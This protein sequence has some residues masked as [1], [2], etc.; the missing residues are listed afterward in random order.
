MFGCLVRVWVD[1]GNDEMVCVVAWMWRE[2]SRLVLAV[3]CV[4]RRLYGLQYRPKWGESEHKDFED[5]KGR[6]LG[7]P[8][9]GLLNFVEMFVVEADA[10]DVGIGT[11]C[12][13]KRTLSLRMH[14]QYF[15]RLWRELSKLVSAVEC[16]GR[17]LYGIQYRPK[18]MWREASRLVLAVECVGR[19]LYGLQYRPKW[20][21]SEHKDFE[22]LKGRMLG[23][24]ILGLLNF[25]EMFVVEADASDAGIGT[26]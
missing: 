24:P 22:D 10:L 13:M 17:R 23:A 16:V 12:L 21:E 11:E 4:G 3:E 25:V 20:G 5:L 26:V 9:L 1:S 8:I 19:Q 15:S 14:L 18:V 6:M 7:A 2:A